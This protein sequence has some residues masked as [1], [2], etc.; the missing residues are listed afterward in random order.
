MTLNKIKTNEEYLADG[1]TIEELPLIRKHDELF[2]E[3]QMLHDGGN[4]D[5]LTEAQWEEY[6]NL[7]ETLGL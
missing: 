1:F 3:Y 6:N 2:N 4:W 7:V 5:T